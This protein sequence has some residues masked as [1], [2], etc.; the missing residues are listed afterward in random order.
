MSETLTDLLRS[1]RI[2]PVIDLADPD[3]AAPLAESLVAGG[4]RIAE[5]TLRSPRSLES[6]AAMSEAVQA[7]G[8]R[9]AGLTVLAG[10]VLTPEDFDAA[11]AA[12]AACVVSPGSTEALRTHARRSSVPFVPGVATASEAMAAVDDGFSVMKFFPA[13]ILGGPSAIRSILAPLARREISIMPTGGIGPHDAADYLAVPA[14]C[15]VGGS[16]MVSNELL[17]ERRWDDVE[18]LMREALV[19]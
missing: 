15:A 2:V 6:L 11:V 7:M 10:S 12:G 5:M 17:A 9:G 14:V 3:A 13:A 8:E 16:W 4:A 1:A 18:R 19:S